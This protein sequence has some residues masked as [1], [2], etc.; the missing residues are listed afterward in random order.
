MDLMDHA[1]KH[2]ISSP[3]RKWVLSTTPANNDQPHPTRADLRVPFDSVPS[4]IYIQ[5]GRIWELTRL[6][7]AGNEF[8]MTLPEGQYRLRFTPNS[9]TG[10]QSLIIDPDPGSGGQTE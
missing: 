1:N 4:A 3:R 10:L 2:R 7:D 5:A 6:D 8:T 9:P